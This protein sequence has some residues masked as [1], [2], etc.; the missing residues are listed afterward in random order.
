MGFVQE[1]CSFLS[2]RRYWLTNFVRRRFFPLLTLTTISASPFLLPSPQPWMP[3][4]PPKCGALVV[5]GILPL[6][7]SLNTS[8]ELKICDVAV[9]L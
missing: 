1:A 4:Y 9:L 6:V 5:R 7:V 2:L 8:A 3:C